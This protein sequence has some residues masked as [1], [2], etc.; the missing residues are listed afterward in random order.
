MPDLLILFCKINKVSFHFFYSVIPRGF[1][2]PD[3]PVAAAPAE[4]SGPSVR[5]ASSWWHSSVST[6]PSLFHSDAASP[7]TPFQLSGIKDLGYTCSFYKPTLSNAFSQT[8][9]HPTW[10]MAASFSSRFSRS[11][12]SSRSRSLSFSS[13]SLTTTS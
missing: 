13:S 7:R 2:S 9:R 6:P 4:P 12:W 5:F 8:S 1:R 10:Q 11:C 3:I